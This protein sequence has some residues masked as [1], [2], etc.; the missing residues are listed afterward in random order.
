MFIYI[1]LYFLEPRIARMELALGL[2]IVNAD[3]ARVL[4][5]EHLDRVKALRLYAQGERNLVYRLN[6]ALESVYLDFQGPQWHEFLP[7][8]V[9]FLQDNLIYLVTVCD[10]YLDADGVPT[11]ETGQHSKIRFTAKCG[12]ML[13]RNA[14]V[15][16]HT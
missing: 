15:L 7:L 8:E 6:V 9:K 4:T 14:V 10:E 12:R 13:Y 16:F 2:Y 3:A 5:I 11:E 1:F